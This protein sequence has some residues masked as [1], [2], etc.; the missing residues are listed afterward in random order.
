M[1]IRVIRTVRCIFV[2]FANSAICREPVQKCSSAPT[3]D[4]WIENRQY[5]RIISGLF[6]S[7]RWFSFNYI[8]IRAFINSHHFVKIWA[9][10]DTEDYSYSVLIILNCQLDSLDAAFV[11]DSGWQIFGYQRFGN[12]AVIF[13]FRVEYFLFQKSLGVYL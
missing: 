7:S 4:V 6:I 1:E 10:V 5:V 12:T 2:F 13:R 3:L 11:I 8:F 9:S